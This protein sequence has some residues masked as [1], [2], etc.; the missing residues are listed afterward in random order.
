MAPDKVLMLRTGKIILNY[1]VEKNHIGG[2][3]FSSGQ[4]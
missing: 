3:D 1:F 4:A 2:D